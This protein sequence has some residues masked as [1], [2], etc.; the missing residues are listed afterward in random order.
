MPFYEKKDCKFFGCVRSLVFKLEVKFWRNF[1]D[2][3]S[4][5]EPN[6]IVPTRSDDDADS[7]NVMPLPNDRI[8]SIS[9]KQFWRLPKFRIRTAF[10]NEQKN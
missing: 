4:R 2:A 5:I 1:D 8:R 3:I 9:N 10:E 7:A 6:L